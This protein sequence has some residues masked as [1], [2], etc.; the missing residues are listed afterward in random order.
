MMSVCTEFR[1]CQ[2]LIASEQC[3]EEQAQ[4]TEYSSDES[5]GELTEVVDPRVRGEGCRHDVG[6][7]SASWV[8]SY[9][10]VG[11]HDNTSARARWRADGKRDLPAPVQPTLAMWPMK[12]V[13]PMLFRRRGGSA[14]DALCK[15]GGQNNQAEKAYPTGARKVLWN[16]CVSQEDT[17]S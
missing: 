9:N 12:R 10:V 13:M 4:R 17:R 3:V 5:A 11:E 8:Y 2:L 1:S 14:R 7:E 15:G 6:T 16:G